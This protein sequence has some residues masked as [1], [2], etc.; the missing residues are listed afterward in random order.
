MAFTPIPYSDNGRAGIESQDYAPSQLFSGD[1]DVVTESEP[2]SGAANI[3][4]GTVLARQADGTVAISVLGDTR[5]LVGVAAAKFVTG[6]VGATVNR[7]PVFK[8]GI[9]NPDAL[10]WDASYNTDEKKRLAFEGAAPL[11]LRKIGSP[12]A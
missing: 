4:F 10:T 9:F 1:F 11:Y 12:S 2:I 8:S 7:V 3:A 6:V 5:P